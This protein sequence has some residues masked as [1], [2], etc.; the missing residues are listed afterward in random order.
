M[1]LLLSGLS[2]A[3]P[4]PSSAAP[5]NLKTETD[6]FTEEL[7]ADLTGNGFMV[8]QGH[9]IVY[10]LEPSETCNDF[11]YP[12]LNSCLGA[13]PAAP[14]VIAVVKSWPNEYVET[15]TVNAFGPVDPGYSP[16]YRL[17]PREAIVIYGE[18]PPPGRYMGLQTWVWSQHGRWK[19]KDYEMWKNTPNN[20]IPVSLLFSK[21]PPNDSEAGRVFS[22]SALGD[23]IN[24]VVME[25][26][27]GDPFGKTRYFII[28][29]SDSTNQ[30]VRSALQ[31][32]GVDNSEIFT[33]QI[34]SR[35]HFG[36]IGP[37][38]MGKNA[39]DFTTWFRYAIPD[40]D[41]IDAAKQ[42]RQEPP[43]KVL[44]VRAPSY[45]GPVKR[46]GSLT[47][48]ARTANSEAYLANDMQDLI[49]A[50]CER[51]T[52]TANLQ[53]TD[54]SQSQE[55]YFMVDP[56]RELGW[57]GPYCREIGMN[58][59]GD[60]NDAAYYFSNAFPIDDGQVY[61]TVGTLATET[62]NATYV[63]M[64]VNDAST[65]YAPA[66]V[67]D[68]TLKGSADSYA[69]TV[70]NTGMFYVHFFTRNCETLKDLL[71]V[72]R[73]QYDCTE[74]DEQMVPRKGDTNALGDPNLHGFIQIGLRDY[75]APNTQRGPDSSQLLTPR[76]LSFTQP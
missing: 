44:R 59:D 67:G 70:E 21:M 55:T 31:S 12:I 76:I 73:F 58:C 22:F 27:S 41:Y 64:G 62:G 30:A 13:N 40:P 10:S 29:P 71:P 36:P 53:S 14:Y 3:V 24:N 48:Q 1:T 45:L 51:V 18:M 7:I 34:P 20:P 57:T 43:L 37:L 9:P 16:T 75:V 61:A 39:I 52:S 49:D 63:G 25:N 19:T 69:D 5:Q 72:D 47:F 42:W 15:A 11:T 46:Y 26:Q 2:L 33:E 23:I 17:D 66:N 32:I 38:G 8:S 6:E 56:V 74:I 68:M 35:D 50:V 60:Q 4:V 28:T 54:C 65:F